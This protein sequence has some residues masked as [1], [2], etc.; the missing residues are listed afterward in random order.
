MRAHADLRDD[1]LGPAASALRPA[2]HPRAV[3]RHHLWHAGR[4]APELTPVPSDDLRWQDGGQVVA[5]QDGS[6][7]A[8]GAGS[9]DVIAVRSLPSG[10]LL[11]TLAVTPGEGSTR[12]FSPDGRLLAAYA[13]NVVKVWDLES[14]QLVRAFAGHVG[15]VTT[16]AWSPDGRVL[17][18]AGLDRQV[19]AWDM[20]GDASFA[21]T[22]SLGTDGPGRF[23]LGHA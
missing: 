5:S 10:R 12:A 17:Y 9:G 14:G 22:V 13:D 6:R 8:L 11:R 16:G 15:A 19:L 18:T 20:A 1:R 2:G 3:G 7:V 4:P 21:R 23:C